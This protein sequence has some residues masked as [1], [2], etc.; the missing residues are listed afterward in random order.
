MNLDNQH[1]SVLTKEALEFLNIKPQGIYLDATLGDAGHTLEILERKG[2][3]IAIDQDQN[4][5]NRSLSR[6]EPKYSV[7]I[8]NP[9][10]QIT[11]FE[12]DIILLKT[13]FANLEERL[14]LKLDGALFDLGVSTH[15]ILDEERGFSFTNEGPLDMRMDQDLNVTAKDLLI[16]LSEKELARLFTEL[17]DETYAKKISSK[18][19]Q[20][21]KVKPLS[22]TKELADLISRIKPQKGHI[23]PA[24]KVFQAL[25]MAVNQER[26][27]LRK[28][29]PAVTK[30]LK[31]GANLVVISFHSGE[32]TIVKHFL[33]EKDKNT[34]TVLTKKPI[35]PSQNEIIN[36]LRARSARLRAALKL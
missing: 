22:T 20:V 25:R 24:T 28:A 36:N 29:L 17:G 19:A 14:D 34:L 12:G 35:K 33:K 5:I 16:A 7:K 30:L 2:R 6:L 13:N 32:D 3:V 11:S 4:A 10:Q 27:A 15:Q 9:N 1:R 23:H 8:A 26:D 18:I 31:P 21:R